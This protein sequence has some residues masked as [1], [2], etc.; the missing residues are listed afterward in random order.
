MRRRTGPRRCEPTA[1]RAG[2]PPPFPA[3][4]SSY[5][6]VHVKRLLP[7]PDFVSPFLSISRACLE[8]EIDSERSPEG[9]FPAVAHVPPSVPN[10]I[11]P[12]VSDRCR[13]DDKVRCADGSF[14]I[15]TDQECDGQVDC[16]DGS[17]EANCTATPG[18]V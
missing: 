12:S 2:L 3:P 16:A 7:F 10:V 6:I 4:L 18:N 15:C 8:N 5:E 9:R 14:Y 17:D 1:L 11:A 13:A